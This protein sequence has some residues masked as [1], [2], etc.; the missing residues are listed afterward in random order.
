M[1]F[2]TTAGTKGQHTPGIYIAGRDGIPAC[3]L[4]AQ[5][6]YFCHNLVKTIQV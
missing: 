3:D 2:A 4:P 6:I 1:A 5:F